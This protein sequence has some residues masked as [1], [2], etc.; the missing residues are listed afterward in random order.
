MPYSIS[1]YT[2]T[3][4]ATVQ[5]ATINT[6]S[7]AITLIGRDYAGYG[8]FLNENFIYL[9]ENFAGNT[10][11]Q[12]KLTGQI[13]YDTSIGTLKVWNSGSNQWKPVGS[14]IAQ[15]TAPSGPSLGDLWFDTANN[16]LYAYNSGWQLIGPPTYGGSGA[17]AE[18]I[19]DSSD[20]PHIVIKFYVSN[21][22]VGIIS[23]DSTFT[24]KNS[25]NGFTVINPGFN[26]VGTN[27][28]AGA[29]FTG[30]VSNALK[31]N[32]IGS[33]QFLRSD[34]NSSMPYQLGV[35][36]LLVSSSL[37]LN[38]LA[39]NNEVQVTSLLNGYN[40]NFYSNISGVL[41]R[42]IGISGSSGIVTVDGQLRVNQSLRASGAFIAN[43]TTTLVD[44]TT[45]QNKIIPS[46]N[47]S[48]DIG[49]T[50]KR[51]ANVFAGAFLGNLTGNVTARSVAVG[52]VSITPTAVTVAGNALATQSFVT[53][54]V[55][56]AGLNSQGARTISSSPPS[57][58]S[59]GDIWYQI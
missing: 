54:Y 21:N 32:G 33:A 17:I 34:Q 8:A 52:N 59:D 23:Y 10:A 45:L 20:N 53:S 46:S 5:D 3:P 30:D 24:P 43:S 15:S 27:A 31:L 41:T 9:L 7:T 2:G 18:S 12:Q 13:W 6:T 16:Q 51:F 14:S 29:Q 1:T 44:V 39:S 25:I 40:T 47:G 19:N 26:L 50:D 35:G 22:V 11:P 4:V 36:N 38:Q 48:I 58:G 37:S 57:G 55:Q 49:A 28:V 42:T 56:T